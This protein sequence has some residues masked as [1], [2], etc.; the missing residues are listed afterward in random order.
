MFD[1]PCSITVRSFDCR[2]I[3][4]LTGWFALPRVRPDCAARAQTRRFAAP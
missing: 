3:D 2:S 4:R 1:H